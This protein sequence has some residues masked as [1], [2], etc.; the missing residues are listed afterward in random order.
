MD[1]EKIGL[2]RNT[3]LKIKKLSRGEKVSFNNNEREQ[4]VK[5]TTYGKN[6]GKLSHIADSTSKKFAKIDKMIYN[7][8]TDRNTTN[9]YNNLDIQEKTA[10]SDE[11]ERAKKTKNEYNQL[12]SDLKKLVNNKNKDSKDIAKRIVD[13]IRLKN[14]MSLLHAEKC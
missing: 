5:T 4:I 1:L 9:D 6:G 11:Y 10:L 14:I 8:R 2:D 7:S 12:I 13:N 3:Y